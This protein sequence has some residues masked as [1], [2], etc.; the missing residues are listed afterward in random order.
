MGLGITPIK[1]LEEEG[2]SQGLGQP[3]F[4]TK[5]LVQFAGPTHICAS[6]GRHAALDTFLVVK[7]KPTWPDR[8]EGAHNSG[9]PTAPY[10]I[11]REALVLWNRGCSREMPDAP[12]PTRGGRWKLP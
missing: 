5:C 6:K 7:P 9:P 2:P 12:P 11:G 1:N 8:L 4:T 10:G 3:P